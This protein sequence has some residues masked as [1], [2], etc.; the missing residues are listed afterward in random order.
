MDLA[1]R[2]CVPA[3]LAVDRDAAVLE[4]IAAALG[5]GYD[6]C[7][8]ASADE[9]VRHLG[10]R[11]FE[12]VLADEDLE[13]APDGRLRAELSRYPAQTIA[14]IIL[15]T[16]VKTSRLQVLRRGAFECL[17]KP[18]DADLL[19]VL[20]ARA[21]ERTTLARTT[22]ELVEEL[23]TANAELRASRE[24]LQSRVEEATEDLRIKVEELDRARRDLETARQ[25]RDEFINV[26]AH[27]LGGPLTAV[28][29]Y[30]QLLGRQ[31]VPAELHRRAS[32]I[33]RSQIRR[34]ARL[35]QDLA[36]PA[37]SPD[38]LSLQLGDHDLV[39]LLQEQIE[40]ARAL[41][42][43]RNVI[44]EVPERRVEARCDRDR[45]AQVVFNLLSNAVKYS[46]QREIRVWLRLRERAAELRVINDGPGIPPDRL[47]EI[48]EPHVRLV[49]DGSDRTTGRGLGL[50]VARRIAEAHGGSLRA[51]SSRTG[52]EFVL[53]LPLARTG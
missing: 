33:I 22:L 27:E 12:C 47:E 16:S 39:E 29:G 36:S 17:P 15:S 23:D 10:S 6:L 1:P 53:R 21:I 45:V 20:V 4:C 26:I 8:A 44:A 41:G 7:L 34:L 28:E 50:Y 18:I 9:A 40:V 19:R 25:Q 3:V 38:E 11:T 35:V 24:H 5:R 46:G 31:A 14:L 52:A 32:L 37:R 48:F 43:A 13:A 2:R 51:R 42:S 49:E 30:A